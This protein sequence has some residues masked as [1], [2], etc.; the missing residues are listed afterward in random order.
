M[1]ALP[2]NGKMKEFSVTNPLKEACR[3]MSR[4]IVTGIQTLIGKYD[5][6]YQERL[7]KNILLCGGGSQLKGLDLFIE[8]LLKEHGKARVTRISDCVF[9]GAFGAL[10]LAMSMRMKYWE[11]MRKRDSSRRAA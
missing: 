10:K 3:K 7:L 5:P 1:V 6:E 2:A 8:E 9:A 4:P 11:E